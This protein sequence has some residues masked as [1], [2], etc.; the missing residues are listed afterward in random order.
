MRRACAT[1]AVHKLIMKGYSKVEAFAISDDLIDPQNTAALTPYGSEV[2]PL[3][4]ELVY[5]SMLQRHSLP[6]NPR[7]NTTRFSRV[8]G[9]LGSVSVTSL[10]RLWL[11]RRKDDLFLCADSSLRKHN[12]KIVNIIVDPIRTQLSDSCLIEWHRDTS[13]AARRSQRSSLIAVGGLGFS[14][15]PKQVMTQA[16]YYPALY[17]LLDDNGLTEEYGF[18]EMALKRYARYL[19][20]ATT[21]LNVLKPKRVFLVSAYGPKMRALLNVANKRGIETIECQHG[22]IHKYHPAYIFGD[23]DLTG[24]RSLLPK[25]LLAFGEHFKEVLEAD[26]PQFASERVVVLGYPFLDEAVR[27]AERQDSRRTD[28][29]PCI[30]ATS[31]HSHVDKLLPFVLLLA[32]ERPDIKFIYKLHPGER[33]E[34]ERFAALRS[35]SNIRIVAD[36]L[37]SVHDLFTESN[38]HLSASSTCGFEALRFGIP[39]ILLDLGEDS[40]PIAPLIDDKTCKSVPNDATAFFDVFDQFEK[41]KASMREACV[42]RSA[43]FFS[44]NHQANLEELLS[45]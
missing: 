28:D 25:K 36:Y 26:S 41:E 3:L 30:L 33:P 37:V 24:V 5:S 27:L 40:A 35:S 44:R 9:F 13:I 39:S 29:T 17:S 31:H 45:H 43:Y 34:D 6:I 14:T 38:V 16:P 10:M 23:R 8:R 15:A 12:G 42:Q 2:W 19:H 21:L 20:I 7:A 11:N 32:R 4:R 1:G 18:V 22:S